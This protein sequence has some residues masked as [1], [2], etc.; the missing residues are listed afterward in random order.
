[1]LHYFDR[2]SMAHSLEARVPFLDHRLVEYCARIPTSLKVR[3]GETKVLLRQAARGLVPDRIIDK[4]KLGFFRP[5]FDGWLRSQVGGAVSDYLL[6]PSP[7]YAEILDRAAVGRLVA[8]FAAGDSSNLH[9][10]LSILMLE[11]W[12]STYV[13]RAVLKAPEPLAA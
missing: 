8:R 11:V 1:M 13:P 3:R 12:L 6:A 10:L 7:R 2:A 5:A 4:P 9:L